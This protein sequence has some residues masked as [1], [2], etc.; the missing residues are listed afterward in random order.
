MQPTDFTK[1][2]PGHIV[3]TDRHYH[4]FVPSPLPP[5]IQPDWGLSRLISEADRALSELSGVCRHLHN[6]QILM[7]SYVR[8]EAVLSSRIENT[9]SDMEDLF[10]YE[11]DDSIQRAPDV[12]EVA[13]YVK[14]MEQGLKRINDLPICGR[15]IRELHSTLMDG[16]RGGHVLPGEFRTTQNWIGPP[17]CTLNDATF[18]PPP[19]ENL[20]DVL[21]E[22][23]RYVN[24]DRTQEPTLV[25]CAFLHYQFEAIHPFADG[26][27]RVGRLLITLY[28]CSSGILSEPLLYLSEFFER[29]R[30]DYYRLLLGVSQRGEWRE[31]LE[32]FL[33]G[34]RVQSENASNQATQLVELN[35][36]YRDQ[37]GTK[38]V[39]E[40]A[41]RLV[42]HIFSNPL[43]MPSKLAKDWKM[44]FPT[45][46]TGIDR[47]VTLGILTESTQKQRNRIFRATEVVNMLNRGT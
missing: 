17:G 23:E 40:A 47:L 37:L 24:N 30:S 26:N 22:F 29:Y 6:P 16:V 5:A 11:V 2:A 1:S 21:S 31:W 19:A 10:A 27:G 44:P 39:P 46:M 13:N 34:V 3:Q 12:K 15:L 38:R 43:V 36:S 42:D 7:P 41:L 25:K 45:V 35:Q 4:A 8:R 28:L 18:V 9:Q 14:A 20:G 33:R 32:F